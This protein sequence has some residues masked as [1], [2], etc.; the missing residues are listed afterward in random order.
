MADT[1]AICRLISLA[2]RSGVSVAQVI[3]QLRNIG[4][5]TPVFSGGA[6]VSSIPDAIAQVLERHFGDSTSSLD[7]PE[8]DG[9]PREI[10]PTC[11]GAMLFDSG[12]YYCR[13]CGYSTC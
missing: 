5:S 9:R 12:C 2:L 3:R 1:E 11:S 10:C 6:R 7:D 8:N 4:G 13:S